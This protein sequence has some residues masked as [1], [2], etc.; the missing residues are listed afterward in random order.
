MY[1]QARGVSF[2][3]PNEYGH[4]FAR[5]LRLVNYR[6]YDWLIGGGE[7]YRWR[8]PG[9]ELEELFPEEL[10]C[11]RGEALARILEAPEPQYIIHADLKAFPPGKPAVDCETY[12]EFSRGTASVSEKCRK[13]PIPFAGDRSFVAFGPLPLPTCP[14]PKRSSSEQLA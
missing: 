1:P 8:E 7:S 4:W 9:Q 3:I 10:R 11:V 6:E 5:I 2:Q 12:D 13:A 14:R